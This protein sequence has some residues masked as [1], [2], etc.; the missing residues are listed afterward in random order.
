MTRNRL[1]VSTAHAHQPD[2]DIDALR[3][4]VLGAR[5]EIVLGLVCAVRKLIALIT[6]CR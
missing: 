6:R 3:F 1:R 2:D 4:V 5:S